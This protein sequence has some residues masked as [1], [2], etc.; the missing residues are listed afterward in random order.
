M[1]TVHLAKGP[2]GAH[3]TGF[4]GDL[5]L[6]D[7]HGEKFAVLTVMT[8]AGPLTLAGR[9]PLSQPL[10]GGNLNRLDHITDFYV[11][12]A[13]DHAAQRN[14]AMKLEAAERLY[15]KCMH[16]DPAAMAQVRQLASLAKSGNA[17]AVE[18]W[19][20]LMHAKA[21]ADSHA[22][23]SGE[24]P[25]IKLAPARV[26]Q[27][28]AMANA[29]IVSVP[30]LSTTSLSN[31]LTTDVPQTSGDYQQ[32]ANTPTGILKI[33]PKPAPTPAKTVAVSNLL[34][35]AKLNALRAATGRPASDPGTALA[36]FNKNLFSF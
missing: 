7:H 32:T 4:N 24:L 14:L 22:S 26:Q 6:V 35:S 19:K 25:A 1:S 10:I 27:L 30:R 9:A 34:T 16:K 33:M 8:P 11:G 17:Q 28:I 31:Y 20:A 29:A 13:D 15:S 36:D 2:K 3:E 12:A 18:G 5:K 21:K 23:F